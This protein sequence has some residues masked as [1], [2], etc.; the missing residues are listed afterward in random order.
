MRFPTESILKILLTGFILAG[1]A[2]GQ[3]HAQGRVAT[4][5]LAL[6]SLAPPAE[7]PS[8]SVRRSKHRRR[9]TRSLARRLKSRR[10]ASRARTSNRISRFANGFTGTPVVFEQQG[11]AT[12]TVSTGPAAAPVVQPS[13]Q[14][15]QPVQPAVRS[16]GGP[17]V[18]S[19]SPRRREGAEEGVIGFGLVAGGQLRDWFSTAGRTG[20]STFDDKSARFMIGP[21]IQFN[22]SPRYVLEFDAIRRGFGA[23]TTGNIFGVGFSTDSSGSSWEFPVIFKRRFLMA[24]HVKPLLGAGISLRHVSQDSSLTSL[25]GA[26]NSTMN[27]SQGSISVG[28][29]ISAGMDFRTGI[30]HFTPELRYTLWTADKSFTPI[31]TPGLYD[32]NPNQ[33]AFILGFRIN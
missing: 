27:S 15:I 21:T 23:R 25:T 14:V 28:I 1:L 8:R 24:R 18:R 33:V 31:R 22:L 3:T 6:L 17:G 7:Q 2:A 10:G 19:A 16:V 29:P 32:A 5:Q 30:F 20:T 9:S 26:T 12:A 13:V 11:V 4:R